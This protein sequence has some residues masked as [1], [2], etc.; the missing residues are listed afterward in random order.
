MTV[1]TRELEGARAS[2]AKVSAGRLHCSRPSTPPVTP[3]LPCRRAVGREAAHRAVIRLCASALLQP[4]AAAGLLG[5]P[6][7]LVPQSQECGPLLEAAK[8][9]LSRPRPSC[10]YLPPSACPQV[11]SWFAARCD[12]ILLLFDPYKLDISDEFKSVGGA[13]EKQVPCRAWSARPVQ[14][15]WTS[16]TSSSRRV[17]VLVPHQLQSACT[18]CIQ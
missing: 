17:D 1:C 7:L 5:C 11:C 8:C 16:Q 13:A 4:E 14:A 10:L 2:I 12:L 9:V 6:A 18:S 15:G 3:G